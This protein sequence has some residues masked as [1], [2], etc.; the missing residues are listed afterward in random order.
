MSLSRKIP[1][2]KCIISRALIVTDKIHFVSYPLIGAR[3]RL[4]GVFMSAKPT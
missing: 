4:R 2:Y 1:P 3:A